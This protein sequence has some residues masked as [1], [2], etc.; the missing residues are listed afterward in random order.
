M[1]AIR[2][3]FIT[4][5]SL[6]CLAST[7]TGRDGSS[8]KKKGGGGWVDCTSVPPTLVLPFVL[9]FVWKLLCA[10]IR[11]S[12]RRSLGWTAGRAALG[13]EN[14]T[15]GVVPPLSVLVGYGGVGRRV[16]VVVTAVCL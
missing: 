2:Q 13:H 15:V 7:T 14:T 11:C 16:D 10:I 6:S 9:I 5:F 12:W 4:W 3:R 1:A 8:C